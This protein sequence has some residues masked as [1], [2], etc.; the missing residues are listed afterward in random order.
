VFVFITGVTEDLCQYQK[1]TSTNTYHFKKIS[2]ERGFFM[3]VKNPG[4]PQGAPGF[5]HNNQNVR[6]IDIE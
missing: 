6:E 1:T 5:S 2:P 4:Y 3:A